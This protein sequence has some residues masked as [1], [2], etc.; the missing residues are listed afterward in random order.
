MPK[1]FPPAPLALTVL[2]AF[3]LAGQFGRAADASSK[4]AT[5]EANLAEP[6]AESAAFFENRIRPVLAEHCYKCHGSEK[7]KSGLRLDSR[8]AILKGGESG[9]A[10]V[11][12]KARASLMILAVNHGEELKMPPKEKLS[13]A[14]IADLTKW[15]EMGAPWPGAQTAALP[16][17][18]PDKMP[19][20]LFSA[21]ERSFWAFQR[22]VEPKWPAIKATAWVQ[23]PL[24]NFILAKLEANGF[25][26]APR[27][28]KRTLIRRATFDLTGLPPTLAEVEAFLADQSQEAF[29]RVIDRLLA[30]PRYGERWGRHW[31]DVVRYADS[32]GLDENLAFEYAFRYRDY[33]IRSFNAD[34]PYDRF[35]QEQL[36]GDLMPAASD[37]DVAARYERL[38]ATGFLSVGPKMLADDDP[39][40]KEMDI[41]DE[42]VRA[43]TETFLALTMGCARCHDHKFDPLPSADYYSLAGIFK[44][45]KTMDNLGVVAV[46]HEHTLAEPA[47]IE[48]AGAHEKEILAKDQAIKLLTTTAQEE[49]LD[50]ERRKASRYFQAAA[51]SIVAK[52]GADE[53][54]LNKEILAQWKAYLESAEKDAA[55]VWEDWIRVKQSGSE[56][57]GPEPAEGSAATAAATA[58]EHLAEMY[59]QRFEEADLAWKG[60]SKEQQR[61]KDQKLADPALESFRL[62]LY[63]ASG[64]FRL[65]KNP[66]RFYAKP[67]TDE[68]DQLTKERTSL[69]LSRP[70]FPKSM[71]V[72][73]GP[74]ED[75]RVHLRGNYLTLGEAAP[76]RFPRILA[77]ENQPPI[78]S[79]NSG[80]LQLAEWLTRPDHPLTARV[81]VNRLWRWHFGAGIVRTVD[82][83]GRLG[84]KPDHP[85]LLDWL[86]LRFVE[87]GWSIK[88]MH[89]LIM[90]SS[91]YQ[92]SGAFNA[93]VADVDP[94]NHS[95]WRFNRRRLEA[96]E[97]R[98]AVLAAS[99]NLDSAMYGQLLKSKNRDY[100]NGAVSSQSKNEIGRRSIYLPIL[101]SAVYEIL[102]AFDFPDPAVGNGDRSTT[103]VAP[104][105]LFMMNSELVAKHSR[106]LAM[107]LLSRS[108][109]DDAGRI[110]AAY[111]QALS[112][113][114]TDEELQSMTRFITRLQEAYD[115]EKIESSRIRAWQSF[116]R[117]LLASNEFIYVD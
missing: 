91:T 59:R 107:Q 22:P 25:Q 17:T 23:S 71:G 87:S 114:P 100:V 4:E 38:V 78:N 20:A 65:P 112:R 27:A 117:V 2:V 113:P 51:R 11:P 70:V 13:P 1:Q 48:K 53:S 42:Q 101:R 74:I 9:S 85:E 55:K 41:V 95:L 43:T 61:K 75:L 96:E 10:I 111:A 33:V 6:S 104:Q 34:K 29:A 26:P 66:E 83:F 56:A 19:G 84:E 16:E 94:E 7:Q 39:R 68:I 15:V 63:G 88:G 99:E 58:I 52:A 5:P 115:A 14:Q 24:D 46:W 50:G 45:T 81:M 98:D 82:N 57:T 60:L 3:S 44:S 89:R 31:L 18:K 37:E 73:D 116:S 109:L 92:M 90:L 47:E 79:T 21:S 80:R 35:V 97:V 49:F 102:Q 108:D 36:A 72:Q 67:V 93:K 54:D 64:P 8:A 32:N 105:A 76:R 12:G 69:V 62:V 103:T 106:L 110:R 86:A 77:G 28:D 30:S 40:K